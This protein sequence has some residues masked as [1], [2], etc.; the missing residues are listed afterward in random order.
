VSPPE[1]LPPLE[2]FTVSAQ[3]EAITL[4]PE[5]RGSTHVPE[6]PDQDWV[7]YAHQ[8]GG[9]VPEDYVWPTNPKQHHDDQSAG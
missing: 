1:P 8:G 6:L 4:A 9:H 3:R 2:P 7:G 5:P